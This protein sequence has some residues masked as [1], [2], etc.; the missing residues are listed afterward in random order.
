[1]NK[2]RP[3]GGFIFCRADFA[4][5]ERLIAVP[6][7]A[8]GLL[9]LVRP[10]ESNQRE[11][12]PNG[13]TTPCTSR[14]GRAVARQDIPVLAGDQRDPSRCPSGARPEACD[15]RARHTGF[16]NSSFLTGSA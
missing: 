12:R 15:A 8:G 11:S 10:R 1:M 4:R 9:S 5:D 6:R 2:S 16:E 14:L 3:M 7:T 13:A